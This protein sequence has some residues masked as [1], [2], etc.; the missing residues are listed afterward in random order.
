M[1]ERPK[2]IRADAGRDGLRLDRERLAAALAQLPAGAPVVVMIHGFRYA[3]DQ[4]GHCPHGHILS[5]DPTPGIRRVIS[6]PRH[7]GLDGQSGLAIA[8]GWP[9]RGFLPAAYAR[10]AAAGAALARLVAEIG[11]LSP[12][13]RVDVIAHSLG[14][15][16]ALQALSHLPA[17]SLRHLILLTAG[18]FRR[19]AR[20]ALATPAGQ[21]ATV[22]N[23][24]TREN[25]LF[26]FLLEWSLGV[27]TQ[28]ALGQGL[29]AVRPNWI[30]LQIDQPATL[31]A[32]KR[33]GYP[34]AAPPARICHWS[35]YLRP[36]VFPLYRALLTGT[37]PVAA[38]RAALPERRDRRWSRL[39]LPLP[40]LP[41]AGNAT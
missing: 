22:V 9:A 41:S 14:A 2:L 30:D 35:P 32:L 4:P 25:D 27:G 13:R 37:L 19:P 29:G 12:G 39:I 31:S 36:G 21:T 8:F 20:R 11:A 10:A 23:V 24:T 5:F 17:D 28:T 34:L 26:D 40:P 38:L 3:P 7:L 1:P 15:R 16:V 6:W 18:E 33:L